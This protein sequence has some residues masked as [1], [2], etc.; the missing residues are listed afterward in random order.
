LGGYPVTGI[1]NYAFKD[2]SITEIDI[3]NLSSFGPMWLFGNN[4]TTIK[5]NGIKNATDLLMTSY[6]TL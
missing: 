6:G 2:T 1:G 3:P 5:C 4:I